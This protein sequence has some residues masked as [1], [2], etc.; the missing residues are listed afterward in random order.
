MSRRNLLAGAAALWPVAAL[1]Q[2]PQQQPRRQAP[3]SESGMPPIVFVHGNGDSGALWIN[4]IWRFEANGYKRTHLFA[5]DFSNPVALSDDSRI[6][7]FRSS[8]AEAMKELAAFVA[9]VKKDTRRRKVALIA[10]SRGGNAVRNYLRNGGGADSVSHAVL[11][12]TP[13][14]GI[15]ISDSML[16]GSEFNGAAPFLKALPNSVLYPIANP[17]WPN[18]LA[19]IQQTIGT[20]V[21]GDPKSVLSTIQQTAEKGS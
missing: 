11:C 1:G 10:S 4:N 14:K 19:K 20:A 13:N 15:V 3:A 5:I 17:A 21:T 9:Q 16:V 8:T 18:V 12:G 7:P 6:Q 2:Q